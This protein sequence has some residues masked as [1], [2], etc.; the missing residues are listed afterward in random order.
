MLFR[1]LAVWDDHEV[2]DDYSGIWSKVAATSPRDFLRRRA[3]AYQAFYEAM[4][5]RRTRLSAAG[6]MPIYKQ[7]RYGALA[8]FFMLDGRLDL[9]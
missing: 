8:E 5:I 3:A 7:V 1:S 9:R 4:P 6:E 2:Q